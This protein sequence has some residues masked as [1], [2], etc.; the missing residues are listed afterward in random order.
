MKEFCQRLLK[1]TG[2]T[3]EG[4]FRAIDSTYAKQ[5]SCSQFKV[6]IQKLDLKLSSP[7]LTR[8]ILA[9]DEDMEGTITLQEYHNAL[10]VYGC[11]GEPHHDRDGKPH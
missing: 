6:E 3:P 5:I 11:S 9:L 7:Q 1:R 10:E 8:L 2:L 4:F